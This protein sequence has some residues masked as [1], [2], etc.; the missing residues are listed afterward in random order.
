MSIV[1][2]V[3]S[4]VEISRV[5]IEFSGDST[6]RQDDEVSRDIAT[7]HEERIGIEA[8]RTTI[9]LRDDNHLQQ[10]GKHIEGRELVMEG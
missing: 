10:H 6:A 8:P 4:F 7:L 5:V 1:E 3:T 2:K 9:E